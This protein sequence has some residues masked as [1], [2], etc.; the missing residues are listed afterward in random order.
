ME[1]H[2]HLHH[3]PPSQPEP[4]A[5]RVEVSSSLDRLLP[6]LDQDSRFLSLS[7]AK[8]CLGILHSMNGA[9]M[10]LAAQMDHSV[11]RWEADL[12]ES[13]LS[14]SL[15][16]LEL[17]N[18]ISSCLSHLGQSR[19]SLSHALSFLGSS[20]SAAADRLAPIQP[21][22]AQLKELG[23]DGERV[24][25][26]KEMVI[27]KALRLMEGIAYWECGAVLSALSG[28]PKAYL[29]TRK[30]AIGSENSS[31]IGVD[32]EVHEVILRKGCVLREVEEINES[33]ACLVAAIQKEGEEERVCAA[34]EMLQTKLKGFEKLTEEISE[35]VDHLFS[36][37]LRSRNEVIDCLRIHKQ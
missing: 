25:H 28:D 12:V 5:F 26:G 24:C 34:A 7:W 35:E 29:K 4:E 10:K 23:T 20:P 6:S 14:Y 17:L 19:L 30:W 31:L 13:Y 11:N 18:S 21:Q 27:H 15:N 3:H 37:I 32:L 1:N 9:F 8:Q 33:V 22:E 2:L 16:L 36:E